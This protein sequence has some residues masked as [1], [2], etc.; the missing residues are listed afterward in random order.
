[1][2]KDECAKCK[3]WRYCQGNGMH[4]RDGDGKLQLCQ[5]K[6]ITEAQ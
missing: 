3:V 4:L 1:M 6:M 5:Y 2:K